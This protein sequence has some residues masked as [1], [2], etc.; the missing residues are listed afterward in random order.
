MKFTDED[1]LK[2]LDLKIGDKAQVGNQIITITTYKRVGYNGEDIGFTVG[3]SSY[4]H[5]IT[6][7]I[8]KE[9]TKISA[10]TRCIDYGNCKSCPFYEGKYETLCHVVGDDPDKPFDI[11]IA[12]LESLLKDLKKEIILKL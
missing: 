11:A 1:L 7:L 5:H 9:F 10:R 6:E 12:E 4:P 3:D 8:G 2:T